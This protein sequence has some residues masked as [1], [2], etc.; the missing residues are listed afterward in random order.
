MLAV[1]WSLE[2]LILE[3]EPLGGLEAPEQFEEELA[4]MFLGY[5]GIIE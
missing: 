1:S 3:D 4:R 5:L 2:A